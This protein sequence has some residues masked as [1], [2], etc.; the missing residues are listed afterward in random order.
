MGNWFRHFIQSGH[1]E[2]TTNGTLTIVWIL[3][4]AKITPV[5][6]QVGVQADTSGATEK[7]QSQRKPTPPIYSP[8][9]RANDSGSEGAFVA[10]ALIAALSTQAFGR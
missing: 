9:R 1:F 10:L 6:R 4:R 7:N 8:S 3:G 5:L 2:N